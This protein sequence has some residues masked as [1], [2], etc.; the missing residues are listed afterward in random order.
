[1][2]NPTKMSFVSHREEL[3]KLLLERSVRRG[4]FRLA[5]GLE[6]NVYV[7][8][9]L[10][11]C[12]ARG[13]W[14]VGRVFLEAMRRRGWDPTAVGG[15]T[16]GADPIAMAIALASLEDGSPIDAFLVRKQPK[17]HGLQKFIE[18]V[19]NVQGL[20]VVIIDDVCTTGGST[21]EAIRKAREAG[22]DVIGAICLVDRE[23]GAPAKL[24]DE[25]GCPLESVYRLSELL[26]RRPS[27][28]MEPVV[29]VH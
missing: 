3:R 27:Q 28:T 15:L 4:T 18:G 16:M 26:E 29:A 5:S 10:T 12:C 11:T 22:M 13:A 25:L 24:E 9:K 23:T 19:E 8:G 20:R 17:K 2:R 6:S 21:A 1:M 14:L 7:D